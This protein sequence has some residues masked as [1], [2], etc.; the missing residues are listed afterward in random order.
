[1]F[2]IFLHNTRKALVS[3]MQFC[4]RRKAFLSSVKVSNDE[5]P[6]VVM[7]PWWGAPEKAVLKYRN[8]YEDFGCNVVV[9]KVQPVDFLRP[10]LG[11][12]KSKE[13]LLDLN[14]VVVSKTCPV[15]FHCT[16]IGC[17]FY[18]LILIHLNNN[19]SDYSVFSKCIKAQIFDS[20][21][22]G[23]LNEMAIGVSNNTTSNEIGRSL[24]KNIV[25]G[26]FA[27]TKAF[28]V[29]VYNQSIN[30]IK[31]DPPKVPSLLMTSNNDALALPETFLEFVHSWKNSGVD[32][33]YKIWNDSKHAQHFRY[34]PDEY[35]NLV[36]QVLSKAISDEFVR[37]PSCSKINALKS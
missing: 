21:V 6:L 12:K 31:Y 29:K 15:I 9:K 36:Y 4:F 33:S 35:R 24:L 16:S 37:M 32:V 27:L 19:P 22:V 5:K 7:L 14:E 34:H 23:T 1:M 2:N 17:Y 26:Y 18:A 8:L 20:P 10:H 30:A 11:L 13:F 3:P 25:M 28:T